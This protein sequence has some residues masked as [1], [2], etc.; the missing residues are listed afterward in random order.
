MTLKLAGKSFLAFVLRGGQKGKSYLLVA[1]LL[2]LSVFP[3]SWSMFCTKVCFSGLERIGW[4]LFYLFCGSLVFGVEMSIRGIT[5][6]VRHVGG[7]PCS[8]QV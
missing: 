7:I 8:W 4:F 6:M 2:L 5:C 1:S 3:F